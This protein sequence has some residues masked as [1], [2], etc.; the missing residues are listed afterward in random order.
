M[1]HLPKNKVVKLY[2]CGTDYEHEMG[3]IAVKMYASIEELKRDRP[4]IPEC[5]IVSVNV[6]L[7]EWVENGM[8]YS[9]RGGK[10]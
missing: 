3:N 8:P 5:G 10:L 2:M 4:C 1:A 6:E 7:V 9:Q